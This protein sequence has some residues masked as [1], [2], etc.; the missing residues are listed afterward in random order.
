MHNSEDILAGAAE[1][2]CDERCH[3]V[4]LT[5]NWNEDHQLGVRKYMSAQRLL[6][7]SDLTVLPIIPSSLGRSL[8]SSGLSYVKFRSL[9]S[10][11]PSG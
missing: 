7:H 4:D 9:G 1:V 10:W 6:R 5:M 8:H 11:N 3:K 2:R